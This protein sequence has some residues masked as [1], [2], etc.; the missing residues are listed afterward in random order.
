MYIVAVQD[1]SNGFGYIPKVQTFHSLSDAF[2]HFNKLAY[3]ARFDFLMPRRS[4]I[5]RASLRLRSSMMREI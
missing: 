3:E 5:W 1:L 4:L 2:V